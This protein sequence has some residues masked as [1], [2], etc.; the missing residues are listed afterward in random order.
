[1]FTNNPLHSRLRSCGEISLL[2]EIKAL[3]RE[4]C[5]ETLNIHLS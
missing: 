3:Y 4:V 2:M 5:L 1:M